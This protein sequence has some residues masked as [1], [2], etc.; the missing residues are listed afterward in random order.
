MACNRQEGTSPVTSYLYCA[1]MDT[2]Y[3]EKL[4]EDHLVSS[5]YLQ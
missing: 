3:A 2:V 4:Q 5:A 1:F